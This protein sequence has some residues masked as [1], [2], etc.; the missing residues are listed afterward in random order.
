AAKARQHPQVMGAA[1][2]VPAQALIARGENMRGTMVRGIVPDE[3]ISVTPLAAQMKSTM[4]LLTPGTW[5]V[6][7]GAELAHSMDV[8]VGDPITLVAPSGQV[9]PAGVVPRIKQVT[10]VGTFSAGHYEYD[11]GLVL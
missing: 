7:I 3:E 9:T 11:N 1:P 4:A 10:V 8:R 5:G 6:V 2:F